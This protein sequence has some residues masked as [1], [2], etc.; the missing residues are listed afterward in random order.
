MKNIVS[1]E[2]VNRLIGPSFYKVVF[3]DS[4]NPEKQHTHRYVTPD[5]LK[6]YQEQTSLLLWIRNIVPVA[7]QAALIQ[8]IDS[9]VDLEGEL[10]FNR[11]IDAAVEAHSG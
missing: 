2:L 7:D 11:G 9:L 4:S 10:G 3:T 6:S 8:K 1:A 5:Q